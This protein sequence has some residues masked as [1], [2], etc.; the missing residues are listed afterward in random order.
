MPTFAA[1]PE[2]PPS[3]F[4][5]PPPNLPRRP[6]TSGPPPPPP[7]G[8]DGPLATSGVGGR[9]PGQPV[10]D[11]ATAEVALH[12]ERDAVVAV[13]RRRG[14]LHPIDGRVA[15]VQILAVR[16]IAL[17]RP[18]RELAPRHR[19]LALRTARAGPAPVRGVRRGR[20]RGDGR[21]LGGLVGLDPARGRRLRGAARAPTAPSPPPPPPVCPRAGWQRRRRA[22]PRR[23]AAPCHCGCTS[24][25]SPPRRAAPP[26]RRGRTR[27]RRSAG[28]TATGRGG[29]RAWN[30]P[31]TTDGD[32]TRLPLHPGL[33]PL[34]GDARDPPPS[35]R[36]PPPPPPLRPHRARTPGRSASASRSGA[37]TMGP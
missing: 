22:R 8:C 7:E 18:R 5:S 33:A 36:A 14:G 34:R 25:A 35:P 17:L 9:R 28:R 1:S 20:R 2:L 13:E 23:P 27:R 29:T 21:R 11:P 15:G 10:V 6:P 3:F 32:P 19:R 31:G 26:R 30:A 16:A 37:G 24:P 4:A 12:D